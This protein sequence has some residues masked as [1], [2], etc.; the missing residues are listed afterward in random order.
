MVFNNKKLYIVAIKSKIKKIDNILKDK[1]KFEENLKREYFYDV[2]I[3]N[4]IDLGEEIKNI[5]NYFIKFEKMKN[6]KFKDMILFRNELTHMYFKTSFKKIDEF[7][8]YDFSELKEEIKR[9]EKNE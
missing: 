2:L 4:L 5:N 8:E 1:K 3:K 7:L 6:P 9:I